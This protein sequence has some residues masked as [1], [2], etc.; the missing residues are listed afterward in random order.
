M[1]DAEPAK[2][3]LQR[4]CASCPS[5]SYRRVRNT[6]N[7]MP[8]TARFIVMKH[9]A[10]VLDSMRTSGS[11][12]EG[13]SRLTRGKSMPVGRS[14]DGSC[15]RGWRACGQRAPM[16]IRREPPDRIRIR[17]VDAMVDVRCVDHHPVTNG[18]PSLRLKR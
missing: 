7:Q 8:G 9:T 18:P 17:T 14:V 5:G 12:R 13:L 1:R 6:H 16:E 15:A 4:A 3:L 10:G 11:R 2:V